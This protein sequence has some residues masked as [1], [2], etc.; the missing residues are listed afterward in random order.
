MT[1]E[2]VMTA[3]LA[4]LVASKA[5]VSNGHPKTKAGQE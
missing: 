4:A 5:K 1:F 2:A 3:I